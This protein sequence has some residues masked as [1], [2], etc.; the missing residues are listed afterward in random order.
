M[1]DRDIEV[2]LRPGW[3][4]ATL[5]DIVSPRT[6]KTNP[7]SMPEAKFIGLEQIEPHTMRLLG[8]VP[9]TSMKS[10]ANVFKPHD[11]LY[12]RLRAY[13]NKVYQPDFAGICSGEFIVL[14]E[15]CAVSGRFLKY[16]LNAADFVSFASHINTGDRPRVDFDQIKEFKLLLPPR[17]EQER[18][19]DAL[20]ELL[21]DLDAGVAGLQR[22]QERLPHYR[23]ALLRTAVDGNFTAEW[24]DRHSELEPASELLGRV[25][26]ERRRRWEE[27]QLRKFA[28]AGN[29]PP[30]NWNARYR[31]PIGPDTTHLPPLPRK[32][33]WTSL[34]QLSVEI[35]NG[36]SI[37]PTAEKGIPILRISAVRPLSL[38]LD[39]VRYLS[40]R[41]GYEEFRVESGD[42]LFTRYNGT[43]SLVAVCAVVPKLSSVILH[44]D[45][46]IRAR[47][48]SGINGEFVAI[49]ANVRSSRDFLESRIRTTAGQ[50][51]VSG[52]D[53]RQTPIPFAPFAEQEIIATEVADQLSIITHLESEIKSKL[54]G[55]L[56]VRQSVIRRS[57]NGHLV[58]QDPNDEPASE[59]LKRITLEREEQ[60]RE[61]RAAKSAMKNGSRKLD[62]AR[63]GA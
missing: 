63:V 47:L 13:L 26:A 9:A 55:A 11:V 14:P 7:Q 1:S 23:A 15:S 62:A 28:E 54:Q 41:P 57:F 38:D 16:R 22:I 6:G 50:A 3:V 2:P 29:E 49:A 17:P 35:R 59:L 43:R 42:I 4:K 20:E 45:K 12:G 56:T 18:I 10:A 8:T 27:E 19:A 40:D 44:P 33:C 32:W 21:S 52:S 60:G 51:G 53:L 36:Y 37:K 61:A 48:V 5:G 39:D 46:L 30:R 58:P 24:R 34:D 25:L 31:E